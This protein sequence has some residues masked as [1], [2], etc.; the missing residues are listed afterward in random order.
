MTDLSRYQRRLARF[1]G[2]DLE[3]RRR[4][5]SMAEGSTKLSGAGVPT[6]FE[7][8]VAEL[9]LTGRIGFRLYV[10]LLLEHVDG[11]KADKR[12]DR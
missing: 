8:E 3:A 5:H 10:R 2:A 1:S 6:P 7:T 4:E 9:Y 11:A 12:G